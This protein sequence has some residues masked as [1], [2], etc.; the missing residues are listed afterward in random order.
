MNLPSNPIK[1]RNLPWSWNQTEPAKY[2]TSPPATPQPIK[3]T[4][5][6]AHTGVVKGESWVTN[7]YLITAPTAPPVATSIR[8]TNMIYFRCVVESQPILE[9]RSFARSLFRWRLLPYHIGSV[10][11]LD[12]KFFLF[13]R[14]IDRSIRENETRKPVENVVHHNFF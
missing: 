5:K 8:L 12:V 2:P 1:R 14:S 6:V 3:F 10:R 11:N 7:K 4:A 13:Y 9:Y